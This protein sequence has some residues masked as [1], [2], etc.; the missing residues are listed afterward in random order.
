MRLCTQVQPKKQERMLL[1]DFTT[2][3][4]DRAGQRKMRP[5]ASDHWTLNLLLPVG[6]DVISHCR[7]RKGRTHTHKGSHSV[8]L[9]GFQGSLHGLIDCLRHLRTG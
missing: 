9:C 6:R 4:A 3:M 2:F 7:I 8:F 5:T 1:C